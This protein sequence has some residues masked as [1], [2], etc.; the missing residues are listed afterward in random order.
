MW[1]GG[2]GVD[3]GGAP[4]RLPLDD[5]SS[6]VT[7][8]VRMGGEKRQY[9]PEAQDDYSRQRRRTEEQQVQSP[10]DDKVRSKKNS[11]YF[12][13]TFLAPAP[14]Q[15][16]WRPRPC[17]PAPHETPSHRMC[18]SCTAGRQHAMRGDATPATR[19]PD[20]DP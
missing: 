19:K 12:P 15:A 16:G 2:G 1:P 9:I 10:Y 6:A 11:A 3:G 7:K 20:G 4:L 13:S 17:T 14:C 5:G 8:A 18:S